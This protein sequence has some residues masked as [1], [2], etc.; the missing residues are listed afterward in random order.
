MDR[1]ADVSG[2]LL[3]A[4]VS[5]LSPGVCLGDLRRVQHPKIAEEDAV[6]HVQRDAA[7]EAAEAASG[8]EFARAPAQFCV[9]APVIDTAGIGDAEGEQVGS[10]LEGRR[11]VAIAGGLGD[12]VVPG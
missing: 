5:D 11:N 8:L 12:E 1:E 7:I 3:Q 9:V 10:R 2:R 6:M 4:R